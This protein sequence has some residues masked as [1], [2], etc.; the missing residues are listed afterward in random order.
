LTYQPENILLQAEMAQP[1]YVVLTDAWYP[2]WHATLDGTPIPIER[3]N[4]TFRAVQV[5]QGTHTLHFTYRPASYTWGVRITL[6]TLLFVTLGLAFKLWK[7]L[8]PP[9]VHKRPQAY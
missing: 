4:L 9:R 8:R 2:G 5:P 3:A 7:T 6:F 1:G